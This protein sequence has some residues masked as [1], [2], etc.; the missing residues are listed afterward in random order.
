[1]LVLDVGAAAADALAR[2]LAAI[3][4]RADGVT[5]ADHA[6][7]LLARDSPDA[8]VADLRLARANDWNLL[9]VATALDRPCPS[10]TVADA[11]DP[12]RLE[13]I[14]RG[15][16]YCV[17]R[18]FTPGALVPFIDRTLAL[19]RLRRERAV[20]GKPPRRSRILV[21]DDQAEMAR[22]VAEVL[23][24]RGHDAEPLGSGVEALARIRRGGLDAVVTDLRMPQVDGL[25]LL[26]ASLRWD[27][28]C[29]VLVMTSLATIVTASDLMRRGAYHCLIKPFRTEELC[30]YVDRAL[31]DAWLVRG[32]GGRDLCRGAV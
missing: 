12:E 18:P 24:A 32:A 14:R 13:S 22:L 26:D 16:F 7:A 4:Y 27:P 5:G 1:V 25:C 17:A 19:S 11:A 29:P 9:R 31:R 8:I 23:A 10:I 3:G 6:A 2:A 21:V 15:A 20:G 30:V 28:T